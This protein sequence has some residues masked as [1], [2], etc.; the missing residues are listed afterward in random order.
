MSCKESPETSL[1]AVAEP[2]PPSSES[3]PEDNPPK[4][5]PAKDGLQSMIMLPRRM[6][7]LPIIPLPQ[8]RPLRQWI[9]TCDHPCFEI[10]NGIRY[11]YDG[12]VQP[13]SPLLPGSI[14]C[15]SPRAPYP[16][17]YDTD[18]TNEVVANSDPNSTE[19]VNNSRES[20]E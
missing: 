11:Y 20:D 18:D 5:S 6:P 7:I 15:G 2:Q 1:P 16:K 19:D 9:P 4:E 3:R 13:V 10:R 17:Q 14:T 8:R 12:W